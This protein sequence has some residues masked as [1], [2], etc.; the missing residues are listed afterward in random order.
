MFATNNEIKNLYFVI[1]FLEHKGYVNNKI[2]SK[3]TE[4]HFDEKGHSVS[5][6]E[7]T[8]IGKI[9]DNRKLG[10]PPLRQVLSYENL[11]TGLKSNKGKEN[12]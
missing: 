7:I 6:M 9:F 3:V 4:A 2:L 11:H 5:D 12:N 10:N 8:V 1:I